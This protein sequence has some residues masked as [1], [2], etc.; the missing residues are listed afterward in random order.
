VPVQTVNT[1]V[2]DTANAINVLNKTMEAELSVSMRP[3]IAIKNPMDDVAHAI[4]ELDKAIHKLEHE[5]KK[6]IHIHVGPVKVRFQRYRF[7]SWNL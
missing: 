2:V 6:H 4:H 1:V 7:W 3:I 5:M